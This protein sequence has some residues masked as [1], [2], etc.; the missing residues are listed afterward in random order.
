MPKPL[1]ESDIAKLILLAALLF[2]GWL[3]FYPVLQAGFPINDGGMFYSMIED[4]YANG[5]VLP[6][7][8]SYNLS[9]IPYAYPPLGFYL[10]ALLKLFG[11]DTLHILMYLP[12]VLSVLAI[13][14]FFL[15]AHQV[16]NGSWSYAALA[17]L[18]LA[19]IPR[20]YA[21]FV[22]GGGLTRSLG[23]LF[24]LLF[25]ACLLELYRNPHPA[26]L[27]RS[28][29]L[30]G[31]A[32]LSHPETSIHALTAGVVFWLFRSRTWQG[33]RNSI[34]VA[35]IALAVSSVW[36]A[37]T[38][39]Q[40]G[41]APFWNALQ[42]GQQSQIF[43]GLSTL[44]SFRFTEETMAPLVAVL[45]LLGLVYCLARKE[46]FLPTWLIIHF[47]SQPRSAGAVAIYPLALLAAIALVDVILPA[48][49]SGTDKQSYTQ[50]RVFGNKSILI[51]VTSFAIY[52]A[53]AGSS[54]STGLGMYH[55]SQQ[56]RNAL[57]WI[58][59]HT[60]LEAK[61]I[62]LKIADDPMLDHSA[63][64]FPALARRQSLFTLQG[65]EW[66]RGTEFTKNWDTYGQTAQCLLQDIACL[67]K[68]LAQQ[69]ARFDYIYIAKQPVGVVSEENTPYL[70]LTESLKESLEYRLIYENEGAIVF[71]RE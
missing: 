30:G 3:R 8:T 31:L 48:I 13:L 38:L 64:W 11:I 67:E 47:I 70:R 10:G 59:T 53:L 36:W 66:T 57:N 71:I 39:W 5:F 17:T 4:L 49:A 61:F 19:L 51:T 22:M 55:L 56:E 42:T 32:L 43:R 41:P 33:M 18:A 37:K 63:E 6:A 23:H 2:G 25:L 46:Y 27:W 24:L 35:L 9:E 65:K 7:Y 50:T 44:I 29:I 62:I 54:Y 45:G 16:F 1:K 26:L 34:L 69:N 14:A 68:H 28:G 15:L 40:H 21:S 12:P 52:L 58:Q 20:G 60:P